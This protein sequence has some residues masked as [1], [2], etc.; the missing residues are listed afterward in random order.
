MDPNSAPAAAPEL[1]VIVPTYGRPETIRTL[2]A[3]LDLQTLAPDRFEVVVVDDGTPTPIEVD[4]TLHA[5]ALKLL[6][7]PN[8]GPGAAR[9]LALEHVRAPLTLILNDDAAP[10]AD[11]LERHLAA[12]ADC[13]PKTALLGSFRF[14]RAALRSPFVQILQS[15]NLLFDFP[16]LTTASA[17]AGS[18]SGPAI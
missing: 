17:T 5:Y 15:S 11:L 2:L 7:Q 1:S 9:N 12:H 13:E 16:S 4:A 6:R 3:D 10:A 18:T 14:T 8:A